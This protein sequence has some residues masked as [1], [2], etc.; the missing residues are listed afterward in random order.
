MRHPSTPPITRP[1]AA[2]RSAPRRLALLG[3]AINAGLAIVKFAAG[4]VGQ[5]FALVADAV[6]SLVD[7]AGSAVVW[8]AMA[9]GD[10]P[11]DEAHPYGHGR[12]EAIAG[13]AVAGLVVAA[14]G[15][16]AVE[17]IDGL[18]RPQPVPATFTLVVLAVV[19]A[20]KWT[21]GR[22]A[23]RAADRAGGSSAGEADAWHHHA[24]AITS[25]FAFAGIAIAII[26]GDAWAVAD[27]AAA[28]AASAVIVVNGVRIARDPMQELLDRHHPEVAEA[29]TRIAMDV[30]GV[31][32]VERCEVR[33]SGRGHRV[34][35]HAEVDPQM[36]VLDAHRITGRIKAAIRGARA[37]VDSVLVH[38][39]PATVA[40][41]PPS[42]IPPAG[43]G[44]ADAARPSATATNPPSGTAGDDSSGTAGLDGRRP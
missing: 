14:G 37:D 17:A 15:W 32:G 13:L 18:R 35:M 28:L 3:I 30:P 7:I 16:I 9:Y 31:E 19:I 22:A 24:D 29:V 26:G 2:A 25:G 33:R 36:T 43:G 8:S 27:D 42:S 20:V 5:S 1:D 6:E 38:V 12:M 4:V 11:P 44:P 34:T 40:T 10:R 21:L 39:E 41:R 23:A